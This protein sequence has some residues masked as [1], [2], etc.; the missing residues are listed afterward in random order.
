MAIWS[1]LE[2]P[3]HELGTRSA[4]DR[5]VAVREGGSWGAFWFGPLWLI[6]RRMW[7][8]LLAWLAVA[9]L[10][11]LGAAWLRPEPL[12]SGA[13]SL[14]AAIWFALEANGLRRWTL[15]RKGW[16]LAGMAAGRRLDEAEQRWFGER[17]TPAALLPPVANP[18]PLRGSA[19]E[20]VIGLFP[21]PLPNGSGR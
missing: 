15:L 12:L 14:V 17:A 16:Q 5:I 1:M 13:L 3:G 4:A 2:P 8:V 18:V 20:G 21:E 10:A 19:S 9:V 7:W 11:S 6:W